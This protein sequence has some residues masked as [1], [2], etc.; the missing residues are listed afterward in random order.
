MNIKVYGKFSAL[1]LLL[2]V[3]SAC[4]EKQ[5]TQTQE[6]TIPVKVMEVA[7]EQT[8]GSKNYVGTVEESAT[9]SLAF[10][11]MG[12]VEE[13]FVQ[14]GQRVRKGQLLAT[15][16][17]ATSENSY[18]A[19]LAKLRQAQDAYDRLT[20]V[21]SNGSLPDIKFVEVETGLQQAKSMAAIAKKNLDDCKLYAPRDGVIA[22]RS[23][24]AGGSIIPSQAAFKLVSVDKLFVKIPV[25][26]N[27]IGGIAEGQVA[28][29]T[30]AA[31]DNAAFSGKVEMKGVS[32]SATSHTYEAK[33]GISNPQLQIMP[34][35]VC[36]VTLAGNSNTEVIVVPNRAVQ[37]SAA[38]R[39][40]VWLAEGGVAKRRFVKTGNLTDNGIAIAEGLSAG[41][42]L[43]IEGFQKVSEGMKISIGNN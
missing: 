28:Q 10:S 42:R 11:L 27:E 13:V 23:V 34:G 39:R 38:G 3:F 2:C 18:Q 16:N 37:I 29:V 21:H 7:A 41:D 14:E 19:S 8:A 17:A 9:V 12:T 25:P 26:E 24:E 32:A 31:L 43:I 36:K 40:Y 4:S 22:E 20:K 1:T 30:I 5:G 6:K 15:L 33:I 35:M